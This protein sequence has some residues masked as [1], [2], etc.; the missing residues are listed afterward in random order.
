MPRRL[1][2]RVNVIE[3]RFSQDD[4]TRSLRI[5]NVTSHPAAFHNEAN[6]NAT[7]PAPT[8]TAL[9]GNVSN[10]KACVESINAPE[11]GLP[12]NGNGRDPV[13]STISSPLMVSSDPTGSSTPALKERMTCASPPAGATCTS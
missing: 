9:D 13:A 10:S 2:S 6:S 1:S 4:S 8:I 12:G 7:A 11:N 5:S 3:A